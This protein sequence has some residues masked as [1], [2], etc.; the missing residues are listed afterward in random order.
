VIETTVPG[1]WVVD[2]SLPRH[3]AIINRETGR[4]RVIGP[5]LRPQGYRRSLVNYFDR[6]VREAERRN[7]ALATKEKA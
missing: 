2:N 6:A 5:V 7:L 4:R 3:W 1:P